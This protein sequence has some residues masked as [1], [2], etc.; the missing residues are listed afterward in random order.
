M[1]FDK[2]M[3]PYNPHF[4]DNIEIFTPEE[5]DTLDRLNE[6]V[7]LS[8]FLSNKSYVNSLGIDF[9][10]ASAKIEGNRYDK[11]DT[12]TLLEYGLTAGGKRYS[13]AKMILNLRDAYYLSVQEDLGASKTT[14]KELHYILCDEMVADSARATPREQAVTIS[15]CEYVPL[16]GAK[17][18]D[19]ALDV[20]FERYATI[21]NAFDQAIYLHC[22]LAYLQYFKDCNKRTAR[23]MLNVSLKQSGK[24]LYIPSEERV[25]RYLASLVTYYETGSY[26]AFKAYFIDEYK[27]VVDDV[28]SVENAKI[29]EQNLPLRGR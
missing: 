6:A 26:D 2:K 13:D 7:S 28:L 10:H 17:K 3:I 5:R 11:M 16:D 4:L 22:N 9:I 14:L 18:L 23:A 1:S 25:S 27:E 19:D 20:M 24:M 8:K 29:V 21:P 12:L 15:G